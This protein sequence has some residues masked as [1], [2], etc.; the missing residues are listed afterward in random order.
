MQGHHPPSHKAIE[1]MEALSRS[2]D[3]IK[4]RVKGKNEDLLLKVERFWSKNEVIYINKSFE[5]ME[6]HQ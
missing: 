1:E 5:M 4:L 3:D 6:E 2:I